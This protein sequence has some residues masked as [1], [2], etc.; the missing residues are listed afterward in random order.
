MFH[1]DYTL[2]I[3]AIILI[4]FIISRIARINMQRK[5]IAFL[6]VCKGTHGT[7]INHVLRRDFES[8]G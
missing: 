8:L 2:R 5:V 3:S 6:N 1:C 7:E 4:K